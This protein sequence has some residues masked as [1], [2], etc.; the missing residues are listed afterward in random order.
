MDITFILP[1]ILFTLL[2]IFLATTLFNNNNGASSATSQLDNSV[3]LAQSG[4][5]EAKPGLDRP[6]ASVNLTENQLKTRGGLTSVDKAEER[7]TDR[8][9]AVGTI[10]VEEEGLPVTEFGSCTHAHEETVKMG[11]TVNYK[12]AVSE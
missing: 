11:I 2:A 9:A 1:A 12:Y 3:F 8:V 7:R 10:A 4:R 6:G 5:V